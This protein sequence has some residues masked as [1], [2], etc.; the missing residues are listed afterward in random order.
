MS[1]HSNIFFY[2]Y[3]DCAYPRYCE[4]TE[5]EPVPDEDILDA[6]EEIYDHYLPEERSPIQPEDLYNL[7]LDH[8]GFEFNIYDS[9]GYRI[10][11]R[12]PLH[13]PNSEPC[14]LLADLGTI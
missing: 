2:S 5:W 3:S 8:D 6:H 12:I 9:D 11:R 13:H 14:G 4:V 1:M 10:P 7:D